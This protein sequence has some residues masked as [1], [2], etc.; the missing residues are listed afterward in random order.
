MADAAPRL[1]RLEKPAQSLSMRECEALDGPHDRSGTGLEHPS[2]S[3]TPPSKFETVRTGR[4]A[5]SMEKSR[6]REAT[7]PEALTRAGCFRAG[8]G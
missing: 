2:G 5:I 3:V 6:L 7:P 4:R 8:A 1:G